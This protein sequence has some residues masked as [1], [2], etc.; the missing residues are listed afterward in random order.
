M[1][2]ASPLPVPAFPMQS[3]FCRQKSRTHPSHQKLVGFD[4]TETCAR[5]G[6]SPRVFPVYPGPSGVC[7]VRGEAS[8]PTTLLRDCRE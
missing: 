1:S 7:F 4:V 6:G 8:H 2:V 3:F 5:R